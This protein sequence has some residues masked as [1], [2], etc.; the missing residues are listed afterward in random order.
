[1]KLLFLTDTHIRGTSPINRKDDFLKTLGTK[2]EEVI[3]LVKDKKVDFCLHGGDMF[4]R[5]DISPSIVRE[6]GIILRQCSVPIYTVAGNHDIYG[7][8]PETIHRTM[9]GL[10]DGLGIIKLLYPGKKVFLKKDEVTIQLTGQPFHYDLDREGKSEG[11]LVEKEIGVNYAIHLVHGLLL[12]KPL[13]PGIPYTLIE[14]ILNTQAD[15][16]LVGHYHRGF[17]K[18]IQMN[19]KYFVNPGS[20]VRLEASTAEIQRKPQVALIELSKGEVEIEM[21]RLKSALPGSV[22][23]DENQ[24]SIRD[25]R[26][27]RMADFVQGIK[28]VGEFKAFNMKEIMEMIAEK[29]GLK[30]KV[31]E[32]AIARIGKAQETLSTKEEDII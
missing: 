2:L 5:P 26:E 28:E 9:L 22:V 18:I 11:Y 3:Q 4:D 27:K 7:H 15:I 30:P 8:N 32:E 23:L 29:E 12:E 6:L 21:Y 24:L 16:T 13:F 10:L 25:Y 20:L 1:M 31:K 14:H 19:G 17:R